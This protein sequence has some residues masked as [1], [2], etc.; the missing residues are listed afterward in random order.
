MTEGPNEDYLRD[1]SGLYITKHD[2]YMIFR[3]K[4]NLI[5]LQVWKAW[6]SMLHLTIVVF[7]IIVH[8]GSRYTC[9]PNWLVGCEELPQTF[10]GASGS[11]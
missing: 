9:E 1:V 8:F 10:A 7:H 5:M 4:V 6:V 2:F 11:S 3:S